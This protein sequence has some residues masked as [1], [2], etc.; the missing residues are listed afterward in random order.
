MTKILTTRKRDGVVIQDQWDIKG[1]REGKRWRYRLW[2]GSTKSY[3]SAVFDSDPAKD[4]HRRHPGCAAGDTWAV[5]EQAKTVLKVPTATNAMALSWIGKRYL[6]SRTDSDR[7]D[8]HLKAISWTLA[9]AKEAGVE[10]LSSDTVPEVLQSHLRQLTARRPGQKSTVPVSARVK[11]HHINIL[12]S[13]GDYAEGR[14]WVQRNPFTILQRF[15]EGRRRRK[16]YAVSEL[17]TL[18]APERATDPWFRFIA[19]AAYTGLRSETLRKLTWPMVR[20]DLQRLHVPAEFTKTRDDVRAPLQPELLAL[21]RDWGGPDATGT[22]VPKACAQMTSD[23]A[24]ERTQRYLRTCGVD[25]D[26]RSVHAFRHTVA[27]LLTATGMTA[28]SVMDAIGH[29]ST[30]S[31]KHYSRG[32]EDFRAIVAEE[33]WGEGK[34]HLRC[35]P[36]ALVPFPLDLLRA[37]LKPVHGPSPAWLLVVLTTFLGLP[38]QKVVRLRGEHFHHAAKQV[39]DPMTPTV[40]ITLLGDLA[41][42]LRQRPLA[43]TGPIF[44]VSWMELSQES[45]EGKIESFWEDI[46]LPQGSR[47]CGALWLSIAALRKTVALPSEISLPEGLAPMLATVLLDYRTRVRA[48]EWD[49]QDLWLV[50]RRRTR[51]VEKPDIG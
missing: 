37:M 29:S 13:I 27:S 28:F 10:D 46:G 26:G 24:N 1:H 12:R 50:D 49:G 6:E 22:I 38:A 4:E 15:E 25:S 35:L 34:F 39:M 47:R 45:L 3:R 44:P 31:S 51:T 20:W 36:P 16:V 2:D 14:G 21:L 7:S 32:A 8:G 42:L 11:N 48:E 30:E 40:G 43:Q 9:V 33:A 18:L 17:R 5:E 19:L 23:R 41:E